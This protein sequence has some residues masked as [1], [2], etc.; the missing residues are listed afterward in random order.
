MTMPAA[1]L[2]LLVI[3]LV[4]MLV[5]VTVTTILL[6]NSSSSSGLLFL[7]S[8]LNRHIRLHI[9]AA[10]KWGNVRGC[11]SS[12]CFLL[13]L[14]DGHVFDAVRCGYRFVVCFAMIAV[15]AVYVLVGMGMG[16]RVRG[17]FVGVSVR[18]GKW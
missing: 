9:P 7:L 1:L 13:P 14:G 4:L 10:A 8:L 16:V 6:L 12:Q 17:V 5:L 15:L 11:T 18:H 2:L 3:M